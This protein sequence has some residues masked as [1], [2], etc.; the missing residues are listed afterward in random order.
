MGSAQ[1]ELIKRLGHNFR[2][3]DLVD[4]ALTHRSLGAKNYERLEFLGDSVLGYTISAYLYER[5]PELSEGELT[6]L[7][8]SLVRKESLAKVAR[9]L[10]LGPCLK[11]GGGE[12]KSGGHDRDSILADTM[13][14]LFGAIYIDA[15]IDAASRVVL[16]LDSSLRQSVEPTAIQKDPRTRLQEFLQKRSRPIPVYEVVKVSG[17][18]HAKHFRVSCDVEGLEQAIQGE[19]RSRRAAEQ[20]A[21]SQ[22]LDKLAD[23]T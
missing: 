10:E 18:A 8:A 2:N 22:A 21:A 15:G 4:T 1:T 9:E 7:R 14:A 16:A 13:E 19:G 5:F 11:L 6:R 17:E 12:L 20:H 23:A 3:S